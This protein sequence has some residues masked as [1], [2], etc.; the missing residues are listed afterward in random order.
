MFFTQTMEFSIG[1]FIVNVTTINFNKDTFQK[2]WTIL[3]R[4]KFK[5]ETAGNTTPHEAIKVL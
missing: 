3:S 4:K 2:V 1:Y 5:G